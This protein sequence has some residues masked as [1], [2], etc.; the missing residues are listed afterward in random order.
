MDA[1]SASLSPSRSGPRAATQPT[2]VRIARRRCRSWRSSRRAAASASTAAAPTQHR[3]DGPDALHL[4][5]DAD[6]EQGQ[7]TVLVRLVPHR[8]RTLALEDGHRRIVATGGRVDHRPEHRDL[9]P[10]GRVD[11]VRRHRGLAGDRGDGGA[12][13]PLL[14]EQRPG[15]VDDPS[16]RLLRLACAQLG[17]T[18]YGLYS[19]DTAPFGPALPPSSTPLGHA[20]N[21]VLN[22]VHRR[23]VF[24]PVNRHLDDTRARVGLPRLGQPVLDSFLSPYL[25][26]HDCAPSFEYPRR[27]LPLQVHLIGPLLPE[28]PA[29]PELPDW[30]PELRSG[31]PVV[32]VT[33]GTVRNDDDVLFGPV[34]DAL[35]GE[36]V[37]VVATTT[38]RVGLDRRLPANFRVE[39]FVLYTSLMPFVSAYVT[40][41]GYGEIQMAL[42]HGVPIVVSGAT[43]DKPE[44]A[45]RVAW[46]GAGVRLR[47]QRPSS[48][49]MGRAIGAVLRESRYRDNARRIAAE[50]A[51]LD[52]AATGADLLEQLARTGRPVLR[53]AD[54][55]VGVSTG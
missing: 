45:V 48:A 15:A 51:T 24:G 10:E 27:D 3:V 20:R 37:R 1:A 46:S 6:G 44:V 23:F 5:G 40:N 42:A 54:A 33:Q 12:R 39:P 31:R 17:T 47:G 11:G 4:G 30:W 29:N 16:P 18:M 9:G 28:P 22:A 35:A 50:I 32:L 21:V 13:I 7:L 34:I 41:G 14:E 36:E 49:A 52:A 38:S 25:Y 19:R 2:T 53:A 55:S 26:L 43:E 8:W